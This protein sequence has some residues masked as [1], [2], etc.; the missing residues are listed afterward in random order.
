VKARL[1]SRRAA[2]R[3]LA[4]AGNRVAWVEA[5]CTNTKSWA[6]KEQALDSQRRTYTLGAGSGGADIAGPGNHFDSPV[7]AGGLLVFSAWDSAYDQTTSH[8]VV[9]S[10]SI[11][12]A[13][14]T[15]CPCP[16]LRTEAGPLILDDVDSGRIAAHGDNAVLVLDSNGNELTSVDVKATAVALTGDDLAVLVP[17]E[18]QDY[19]TSSGK[20][21]H[22]WPL[23]NVDSG[24]DCPYG[25]A[26]GC[27]GLDRTE[28]RLRLQDA[29]NGLVAY[30]IDDQVHVL[31][32]ADGKDATVA[33]GSHARF[34]NTGLVVADGVRIHLVPYD[35][36]SPL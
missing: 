27:P 8:Y 16:T 13:G 6:V 14:S 30:V 10:Q 34:M 9:T 32:L 29:A 15:G 1:N 11:L 24:P 7:G 35:K 28:L 2:D 23:P 22:A 36:L 33:A 21:L 5:C 20:L 4:L 19:D 12:R 31:R 26:F 3:R 18:V 17:G 25:I